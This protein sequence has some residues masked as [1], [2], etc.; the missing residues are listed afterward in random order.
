MVSPADIGGVAARHLEVLRALAGRLS[1]GQMPPT[2]REV[3]A[4]S[5]RRSSRTGQR[6]F[7]ELEA[8]GFIERSPAPANQRRPVKI[9]ERGWRAIGESTVLGRIAA[10]RGLEAVSNEEAY[11]V[12][13]ELLRSRGG[14]QRYLLRVVGWSMVDAR[15]HDGDLVVV[16]EDTDPPEGTVVVA[17]LAEDEVTVKRFYRQNGAVRLKAESAGHEDIVVER[18]EV[19]IQGRV[20]AAIHNF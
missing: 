17:L 14:R 19:E 13:G 15:I 7:E 10:G 2:A 12:A 6:I 4:I 11:S 20:V 18:G 1:R 5:G 3:A 8:A 9:T 16:E